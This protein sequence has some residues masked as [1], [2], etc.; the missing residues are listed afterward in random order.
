[1]GAISAMRI[2][3]DLGGTKIEAIALDRNGVE[4]AKLRPPSPR[5]DS[6]GALA[7]IAEL[8]GEVEVAAGVG[9]SPVGVGMPG[10]ISP[11]TGLVK[12]ANSTWLIDRPFDRDLAAA[13]GR[14]L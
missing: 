13:L 4:R 8:V 11:S 2:G 10:A 12:N 5:G 14:P 1:M 6:P 9:R 7:P 3:V